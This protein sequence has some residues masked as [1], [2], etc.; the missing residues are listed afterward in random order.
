MHQHKSEC[1]AELGRATLC[2]T[3]FVEQS[4]SETGL[5]R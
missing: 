3:R 5:K 1:M 2:L 4:L